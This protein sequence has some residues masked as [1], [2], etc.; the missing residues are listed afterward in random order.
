MSENKKILLIALL[1]VWALC[2]TLFCAM[3]LQTRG[4]FIFGW[5][6]FPISPDD[7]SPKDNLGDFAYQV[8]LSKTFV[9]TINQSP[10][11][12]VI[13]EDGTPL[14]IYYG[15]DI[16]RYRVG[17]EGAGNYLL[18]NRRLYLSATDNS[19]PRYS[20]KQYDIGIPRLMDR[21]V[22]LTS[23]ITAVLLT[24]CLL[25]L[26][27]KTGYLKRSGRA[28]IIIAFNLIII[29][30]LLF[31]FEIYLRYI[32]GDWNSKGMTPTQRLPYDSNYARN[33]LT[34]YRPEEILDESQGFYTWGIQVKL[35][36]LGFREREISI[37]KPAGVYRV[38]VLGDS[39]TYGIG[40]YPEERYTNLTEANLREKFH[41]KNIEVLN[42][43]RPG[44]DLQDEENILIKN[45]ANIQPDLIVIGF[46]NNDLM[47]DVDLY[48]IRK[49]QFEV[50][51]GP[52]IDFFIRGMRKI[53][54]TR[55]AAISRQA[56][57]GFLISIGVLPSIDYAS[58]YLLMDDTPE[59]KMFSQSLIEI[60]RLSDE[61]G[62]P[63]PVFLVLNQSAPREPT[64]YRD[65][66][67]HLSIQLRIFHKA[68]MLAEAAGYQHFNCEKEFIQRR[69]KNLVI[70]EVDHHPSAEVNA[71]YADRLTAVL[72]Q[73]V[74]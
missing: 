37:P 58:E 46:C 35:N 72:L 9:E 45:I 66:S 19:D 5:E 52:A 3:Q 69:P 13:F 71:I 74:K 64:D 67:E 40:L 63:A 53:G 34:Y 44:A 17:R 25:F 65:L 49:R 43:S 56:L 6:H 50:I 8:F 33:D 22:I 32:N 41:G 21:N 23:G 57:N 31:S 26:A 38:I 14:P 7:I 4:V 60:K 24:I 27:Y 51:Y 54:L 28:V 48:Q 61:K 11:P 20:G 47:A 73:I 36:S 39:L 16:G 10:F 68:E 1:F 12:P 70:N 29:F 30:V 18:Q 15:Q 42:L 2:L 55:L 62:L 59:V